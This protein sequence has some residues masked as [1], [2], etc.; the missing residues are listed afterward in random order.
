MANRSIKNW[1]F[2]TLRFY[3][4]RYFFYSKRNP[5]IWA[6]SAWEGNRY[7][8]NC[9]YFYEHVK[10]NHK[11]IRCVWFT[12]NKFVFSK[13]KQQGD[14]VYF[15]GS[16][17]S[18]IMQL[19]AGISF[20]TNGMDDFGDN[21]YIYGSL[22]VSLWHGVSFKRLYGDDNFKGY[23]KIELFFRKIKNN[24]FNPVFRDISFTT[25]KY[26]KN[27]YIAQFYL[28]DSNNVF[29]SGQPRNDIFS[30]PILKEEMFNDNISKIIENKK[31]ILYM[32]THQSFNNQQEL[33]DIVYS[34][35][36]DKN[37]NNF[38]T[39]KNYI[40]LLKLH[41][42]AKDDDMNLKNII[43][44]KDNMISD[45]QQLLAV[46]D[47]LITDYSSVFADFALTDRPII[48]FR[49]N[50]ETYLEKAGLYDEFKKVCSLNKVTTK[51]GL[52]RILKLIIENNYD[53][54]P[55]NNLINEYF[56]DPSIDKES[57]SENVYKVIINE[58]T[59]RSG[60][61]RF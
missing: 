44:L 56:A 2:N 50:D 27:K 39:D 5:S 12:Q 30:K 26:M 19:K 25:S 48:F 59:K 33:A 54:H 15:I 49:P 60:K 14:E 41:Y 38:L 57:Y 46:T 36:G 20:Y 34:L 24:I 52:I 21:P 53:Y 6:F 40:V 23:N 11:E 47:I 58:I 29:L 43:I 10:E 55:Q 9:K 4:Q 17:E 37:F 28:K 45:V 31:I 61:F 13:L 7:S 16:A 32:P 35:D 8:D 51:E 3:Y 18:R 1:I 22:I 42:L